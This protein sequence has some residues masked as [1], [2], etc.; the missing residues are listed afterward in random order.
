MR[1]MTID[2]NSDFIRVSTYYNDISSKLTELS[3]IYGSMIQGIS[4][5]YSE[6]IMDYF[7]FDMSSLPIPTIINPKFM[8][9]N[10]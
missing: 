8:A 5:F 7:Q 10:G 1:E 3:K 2:R 9:R 6:A 4:L